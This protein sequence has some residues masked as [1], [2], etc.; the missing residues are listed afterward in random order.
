MNYDS[1]YSVRLATLEA[2]GGDITKHYDS[3]Y[4]IDLEILKLTEQ[5]G[6]NTSAIE[7]VDELPDASES[8][9]KLY[10]LSSD[11]NVYVSELK[12]RTSTT[13]NKL[14]DEQQID[15]AF[16]YE[17]EN[18]RYYYKGAYKI[19][20][21]DGELNWYFWWPDGLDPEYFMGCI[22]E[23]NAVNANSDTMAVFVD[24]DDPENWSEVTNTYARTEH[25]IDELM[26]AAADILTEFGLTPIPAIYNAPESAQINW[27]A[28]ISDDQYGGGWWYTGEEASVE[29]ENGNIINGY[30]WIE[31]YSTQPSNAYIISTKKASEIYYYGETEED[32]AFNSD[33]MFYY[34]DGSQATLEYPSKVNICTLNAPVS[35]QV[36]NA[37]FTNK[38]YSYHPARL[39]FY[40]YNNEVTVHCTDGDMLMY[41]WMSD[42]G[43]GAITLKEPTYIYRIVEAVSTESWT[44]GILEEETGDYVYSSTKSALISEFNNQVKIRKESNTPNILPDIQGQIKYQREEVI[45]EWDWVNILEGGSSLEAGDNIS[46]EDNKISAIGYKAGNSMTASFVELPE[47]TAEPYTDMSSQLPSIDLYFTGE[48]GATQYV[49]SGQLVAII[50]NM[51]GLVA[52]QVGSG[53]IADFIGFDSDNNIVT[54]SNSLDDENA[55]DS[56]QLS[57]LYM[58]VDVQISGD[59]GATTYTYTDSTGG[60]IGTLLSIGCKIKFGDYKLVTLE[61]ITEDEITLSETLD[62]ENAVSN[63]QWKYAINPN[64]SASG[65]QSH[66]EGY[67]TT[68]S[69]NGSH[70]EGKGTIATNEAEHAEGSYNVSHTT[71]HEFQPEGRT[72]HSIGV[73]SG[74]AAKK[75]AFEVM[76]NG[77]IYVY[78]VG[79]YQGTNT[80]VQDASIKTLQAYIASLESR[81]AA[82]EGNTTVE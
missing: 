67:G 37:Y 47:I 16:L 60:A 3:V 49:V 34:D 81:I 59:A 27:N 35:E 42:F 23:D 55:L 11:D 6:G 13:T 82:L 76:K 46:I 8:K 15:K 32:T 74:V 61:G 18:D 51:V 38:E 80:K 44:P 79:G 1:D 31:S 68:A 70:T 50:G 36:G 40:Y 52:F 62:A 20:C 57:K 10:R 65:L 66:A 14:P 25:T 5:G 45:E 26:N 64:N 12:S 28:T 73:G 17:N 41:N 39:Y 24:R 48:A 69:G 21:A 71:A 33:T 58:K 53:N 75:N 63:A 56:A 22:T 72:M 43:V 19:I 54:L 7:S 9:N 30:K 4:E 29:D 2:M 78:G 77:D